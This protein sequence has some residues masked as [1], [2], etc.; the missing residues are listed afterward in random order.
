MSDGGAP[1][2]AL[3]YDDDAYVEAGGRAAGLMGRQVAGRSFLEAYLSH[4]TF[5][6]LAALVHEQTSAAS[7]VQLWREHPAAR[8]DP[9]T[10]RV[11]ESGELYRSLFPD[12]PATIMHAPQPPDPMLAWAR[13]QGG[14][15]AFASR[16]SRTR[17]ARPRRSP[18]SGRWSLRRSSRTTRWS[19]RRGRSRTW[20]ARSPVP[21]ADYLRARLAGSADR[22]DSRPTAGA[23]GDDPAGRGHRSVPS[24]EPGGA[25]R[26]A[27]DRSAWPTTRWRSSTSGGF[28][29]TPRRTRSRCSAAP[30][31]PP[32]HRGEA[33]I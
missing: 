22:G 5:S 16:G 29:T 2:V 15:H 7:L 3:V 26:G 9:R 32:S 18:C 1:K 25:G 31:W 13:Q 14:P 23:A 24:G 10:L 19:A 8:T 6:E 33:S 12:P 20:S 17:C 27:A 21:Y 11:I 30:R 4:G 28:R